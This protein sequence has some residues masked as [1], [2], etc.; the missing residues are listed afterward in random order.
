M[1][2]SHLAMAMIGDAVAWNVGCRY[3]IG[4]VHDK[5]RSGLILKLGGKYR[6]TTW[7][8]LESHN[9]VVVTAETVRRLSQ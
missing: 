2:H 8:Y 7:A 6:D 4:R 3:F 5:H 1:T 9:A